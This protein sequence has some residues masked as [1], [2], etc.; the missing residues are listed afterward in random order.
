M[1]YPAESC[2]ELEAVSKR[3]EWLKSL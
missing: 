2:R 3:V 1:N